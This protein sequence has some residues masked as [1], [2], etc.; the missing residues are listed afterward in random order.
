MENEIDFIDLY[1]IAEI[2]VKT[3][4]QKS[5]GYNDRYDYIYSISFHKKT[6]FSLS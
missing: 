1:L 4:Q 5:N 3:Q 2:E 6:K